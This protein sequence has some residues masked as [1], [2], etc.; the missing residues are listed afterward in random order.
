MNK[1]RC[2]PQ[3]QISFEQI[4]RR[5]GMRVTPQRVAIYNELRSSRKHPSAVAIYTRV[6]KYYPNISLGTVN[7]TLLTFARIGLARVV[8]SSGD[9]KRFDPDLNQHH[10]F[11][12]VKC[13]RIIDF[14]YRSYDNITVPAEI[15]RKYVVTGKKVHLEGL[16]DRCKIEARD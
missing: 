7:T 14:A 12:C 4:C 10:H 9:P 1:K 16:C 5:H 6:R 3:E 2:A 13:G 8:E 15:R 11:R